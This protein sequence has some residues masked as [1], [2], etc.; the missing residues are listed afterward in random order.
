MPRIGTNGATEQPRR[1]RWSPQGGYFTVRSWKGP[2]TAIDEIA[3]QLSTAGVP[4]ENQQ[5]VAGQWQI[6]SEAPN[7]V[8]PGTGSG[9]EL[10]VDN[11]ELLPGE[12]EKDILEADLEVINSI[13]QTELQTLKD[14]ILN[15]A[16]SKSPALSNSTAIDLYALMLNGVKTT[17]VHAPILRH[18]QTVSR[19]W[20]T[21]AAMT[22][23]G[24]IIAN[25]TLIGSGANSENVPAGFLI[26]LGEAPFINSSNRTGLAYGWY[27]GFPTL[28]VGAD[29][30][31]NI[32]QEWQFG[33][34]ATLIYG[35]TI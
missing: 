30:K 33:L 31:L 9:T 16:P 2:K 34:W 5:L 4:W 23:V 12:Q 10:P 18:T 3:N 24:R 29:N 21:K 7:A 28:G 20:A 22:N 26:A 11:W 17:K 19:S 35:D 8:D 6:S 15:P 13:P 32:T 14:G 25:A 27:K 1:L